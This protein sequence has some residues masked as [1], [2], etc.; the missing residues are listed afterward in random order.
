MNM[1]KRT[2]QKHRNTART[3]RRIVWTLITWFTFSG[4]ALAGP[5][6]GNVVGGEGAITQQGLETRIDQSSGRLAVEWDSF[7]V[8]GN[9]SVQFNQPDASSV[10]LNSILDHNPSQIFGAIN[11]NGQVFLVNPNGMIFGASSRLNVAGL[12]ARP[13]RIGF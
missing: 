8:A 5:Q 12:L 10:A 2:M 1:M 3:Q 11:A 4:T 13:A 7:N 6:G 9:E